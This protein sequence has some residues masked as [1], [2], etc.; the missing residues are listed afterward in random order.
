MGYDT[1]EAILF[2]RFYPR[3]V[4]TIVAAI[5]LDRGLIG[6]IFAWAMFLGYSLS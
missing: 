3:V 6:G 5:G 1:S 2:D 4:K